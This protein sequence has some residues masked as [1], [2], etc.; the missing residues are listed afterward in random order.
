MQDEVALENFGKSAL[1]AVALGIEETKGMHLATMPS[2]NL[3]IGL[4]LQY[5]EEERFLRE[6]GI[7]IE[8]VRRSRDN[9][10]KGAMKP[11]RP[12][13]VNFAPITVESFD[14]A[15]REAKKKLVT[16]RELLLGV[17]RKQG[18]VAAQIIISLNTTPRDLYSKLLM[19]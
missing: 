8:L 9:M 4:Q 12:D 15:R 11:N 7:T 19:Q 2:V 5:G 17:L 18:G 6:N 16:S 1:D 3:L 14:L 10:F 13:V